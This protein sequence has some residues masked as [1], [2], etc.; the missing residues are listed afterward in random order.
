MIKL[1]DLLKE[2]QYIKP[3]HYK[4]LEDICAELEEADNKFN[5]D[6]NMLLEKE[7]AETKNKLNYYKNYWLIK[8]LGI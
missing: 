4:Q 5:S 6:N 8:L 7:L 1:R 3:F 2:L